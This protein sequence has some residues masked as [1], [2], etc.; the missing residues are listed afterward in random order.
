[1]KEV[2]TVHWTGH[3]FVDAGLAAIAA[4]VKVRRLEDL[5][6]QHLRKA[7]GELERIL[8]SDQSLGI[9]VEKAFARSAMSQI[10]PNSEL[11]NPSDWK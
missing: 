9:G 6:P 5:T 4:V 1:V 8:L 10:F 11:A 3:P 7:A 2:G